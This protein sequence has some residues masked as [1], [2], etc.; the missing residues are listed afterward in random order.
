[1][2]VE[3]GAGQHNTGVLVAG[4]QH[5]PGGRVGGAGS[6]QGLAVDRDRSPGWCSRGRGSRGEP[7][8]DDRGELVGVQGLQQSTDH[9]FGSPPVRVDAQGE[10]GRGGNVTDPLGDRRVRAVTGDHGAD[11]G[12]DHDR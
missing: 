5:V 4:G 8:A 2:T 7:A 1:M 3:V 6:A 11:S 9:R 10:H 12:A